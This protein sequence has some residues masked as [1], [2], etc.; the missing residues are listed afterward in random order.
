MTF[1]Y[2]FPLV[3]AFFG[4]LGNTL[5]I[6]LAFRKISDRKSE[7]A[8]KLGGIV[9]NELVSLDSI[10]GELKD[11]AK[12]ESIKPTIETHIDTFL[13]VKLLEKMPFLSTFI[14]ESTQA[15][16]KAGMME[17]IEVLLPMV[18]SE[19][20][21]TL[22]DRKNVEQMV[23]DKIQNLPEGKLEEMLKSGLDKE[24]SMLKMAGATSGFIIGLMAL[25]LSFI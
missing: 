3:A 7:F 23:A 4:L 19:Y 6:Q 25:L 22:I 10:T 5:F 13:K 14:G 17:E 16:L 24:L 20:A 21:G 9:A 11:P 12:L 1:L 18:I 2:I 15:K 8:K